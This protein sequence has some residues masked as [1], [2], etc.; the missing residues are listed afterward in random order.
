[1]SY[2]CHVLPHR[3]ASVGLIYFFNPTAHKM[4]KTPWGFGRSE[5]TRIRSR[6]VLQL[7]R[8]AKIQM[9]QLLPLNVNPLIIT[10]SMDRKQ[11]RPR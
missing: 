8:E 11:G 4:A 10:C 6:T 7:V 5:C 9:T 2:L 1:M 3:N